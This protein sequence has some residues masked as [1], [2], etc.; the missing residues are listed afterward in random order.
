VKHGKL[1][2]KKLSKGKASAMLAEAGQ[3]HSSAMAA[4]ARL[5]CSRAG[6]VVK[7]IITIL[8]CAVCIRAYGEDLWLVGT[9]ASYHFDRSKIRNERNPGIGV[10]YGLTNA[11]RIVVGYYKNSQWGTSH[12]AGGIWTP[13]KWG[14]A[15]MGAMYGVI[16]GY[17]PRNGGYIPMVIPLATI[18]GNRFGINVL[19][20]PTIRDL[21][22]AV[23]LQ[24]K[25]LVD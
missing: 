24:L 2:R 18:E 13:L 10:E 4:R 11:P 17:T 8:L 14:P 1:K 25:I 12:Y 23:G 20:A 16:D 3:T 15:K 19:Y 22:G 6:N 21:P 5:I 9:A 7:L